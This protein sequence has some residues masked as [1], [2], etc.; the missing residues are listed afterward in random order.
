MLGPV[1][2]RTALNWRYVFIACAAFSFVNLISLVRF[3]SIPSGAPQDEGL[4]DV[5]WRTIVNVFEPRLMAF[6]LIMSCFW[7]MMYQLWDLQPNFIQDWIHSGP[8]ARHIPIKAFVETGPDGLPRVQQQVLLSLNSWM[9][10]FG[11]IPVGWLVR[12]MRTVS[13]MFFGMLGATAGVLVAGLTQNCWFLLLGIVLF[14]L[15]EMLTGPKKSEYL[16]LI[17]PHGKKG[18]YLGYVNI[19]TGLGQG[20]GNLLA[21]WVYGRF[22]EKATLA[23]RYM[24]ENRLV[25]LKKEW[26][27]S[28]GSLSEVTGVSRTEAFVKLQELL[29]KSGPDVTQ[30][31]WEQYDPQYYVWLP[32]AAIGVFAAIALA[33]FGQMAKRWKDMIA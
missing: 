32:F 18:L 25:P 9:I 17:A 21:G 27:G 20:L 10:I 1:A 14:S 7:M 3:P 30:I 12:K 33:I 4:L 8:I 28:V 19:P 26:D 11:V 23:L 2:L 13:A 24:A 15:G 22:G 29:G 16:G 6:L 31:L 5:M